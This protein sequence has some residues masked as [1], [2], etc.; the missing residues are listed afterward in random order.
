MNP[1]EI[2]IDDN[3]PED[4]KKA[5]QYLSERNIGLTTP[6]NIDDELSEDEIDGT[7]II[8]ND[9]TDFEEDINENFSGEFGYE[10]EPD[11]DIEDFLGNLASK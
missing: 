2:K 11:E 6:I 10:D 1:N 3:M 9:D 5:L 8:E 4:L 7:N